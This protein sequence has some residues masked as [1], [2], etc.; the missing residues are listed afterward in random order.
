LAPLALFQATRKHASVL[1]L[2]HTNIAVDN[3]VIRL[4]EFYHETGNSHL[5]AAHKVV[6]FGDP[7]H[8]D[9]LIAAYR[10][11]TVALIAD[12]ENESL[13]TERE[14]LQQQQLTLPASIEQLKHALERN[15]KT[16]Q[17]QCHS[18]EQRLAPLKKELEKLEADEERSKANIA[19]GIK[20]ETAKLNAV[21]AEL[22]RLVAEERHL[23]ALRAG[24]EAEKECRKSVWQAAAEELAK[25]QEMGRIRRYFSSY[26]DYA[27]HTKPGEIAELFARVG[28]AEQEIANI[29]RSM[30]ENALGQTLFQVAVEK[31]AAEFKRFQEPN[32]YFTDQIKAL[33]Q[34]CA[35][36]LAQLEEI[37]RQ[38]GE[39]EEEMKEQQR[40]LGRCAARLEEIKA[41]MSTTKQRIL[42]EAQVVATTLT[43]LTVTPALLHR[44]FDVVII[45]E[46]SMASL[47]LVLVAASCAARQ[48]VVV[49]DPTQL[50]PISKLYH[51]EKAPYAR[52]WLA[53]D[54]FTYLGI[55][56]KKAER[57]DD[58]CVFLRQQSRMDSAISAP[59]S[60]FVY[61][62]ALINRNPDR[63]SPKMG[64][65]PAHPFLLID[66]SDASEK[67]CFTQKPGDRSRYNTYHIRCDLAVA[68]QLLATLPPP[69]PSY[70]GGPR[71]GIVT[72]YRAQANRIKRELRREGLIRLV[73]V[74]TVHTFQSLEFEAMIFDT[75]E[76]PKID[77]SSFT[78]DRVWENRGFATRATRLLNVAHTR[79]KYKLVYVANVR[80]INK[81]QHRKDFLLNKLVNWPYERGWFLNSQ[82][83]LG[84][85][86]AGGTN[87][88][89]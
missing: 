45:D 78:S 72:P 17:S 44:T 33:Q 16:W 56:L 26:R 57:G 9:L 12:Q 66:T 19:R 83:V 51:P 85:S 84:S 28:K 25:V 14:D 40:E 30:H 13:A 2:S 39:A 68:R 75:V 21:Q 80:W 24:W 31:A 69:P 77:L 82:E 37:D 20:E 27:L 23:R 29:D 3:A 62:G 53:M 5:L 43:M 79:A 1:I 81:Q 7:K 15:R 36:Y 76:A 74:G 46:A 42:A 88:S 89:C 52:K 60:E 8:P 73:H 41:Q 63:V 47:A 61:G 71:I 6:R 22:A 4:K 54:L 64:P 35:P 65:G 38:E 87:P 67:E 59:I 55:T 32:T 18:I 49:G 34:A 58:Y 70:V 48:V 50:A 86:Q 11:I 10:D